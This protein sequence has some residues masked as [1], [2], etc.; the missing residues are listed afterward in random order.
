MTSALGVPSAVYS[1]V[2][3]LPAFA[4]HHGD[5]ELAASPH[6][7]TRLASVCPRLIDDP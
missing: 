6:G 2:V 3:P 1:V 4:T 5:V 7:S